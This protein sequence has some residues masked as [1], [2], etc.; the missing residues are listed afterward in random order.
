MWL[1]Q[2]IS[3]YFWIL[4]I[5]ARHLV[6]LS[7]GDWAEECKGSRFKPQCRQN[8][9]SSSSGGAVNTPSKHC[10]GTTGGLPHPPCDPKTDVVVKKKMVHIKYEKPFI[11]Y[12]F[13]F[14]VN[15]RWRVS[16]EP[17]QIQPC[18]HWRPTLMIFDA[19]NRCT[20]RKAH[21]D[22]ERAY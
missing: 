20:Q 22:T 3:N 5:A 18:Y 4:I 1:E 15:T 8:V 19:G 6:A 21:K 13:I 2:F 14:I 9:W 10:W 7:V 11:E 17:L 16:P 12:L